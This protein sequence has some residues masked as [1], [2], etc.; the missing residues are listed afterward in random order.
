MEAIGQLTGGVAHDFNNIL[1][2]VRGNLELIRRKP[3]DPEKVLHFSEKAIEGTRRGSNLTAQLLTFSRE[4]SPE[5]R[6]LSVAKLFRGL[7][8]L[9]R[10]SLGPTHQLALEMPEDALCVV[11]DKTQLEMALLNTAVNARDAMPDGGVFQLSAQARGVGDDVELVPG[12]YVDVVARDTGLGMTPE[13]LAR[14]FDPFFTTKAVGKG[15]GLGLSQV[16]GMTRRAGGNTRLES[17]PGSGTSVILTLRRSDASE[18]EL[19]PETKPPSESGL[20]HST[21]VLVVDDDGDVRQVLVDALA[22]LGYSVLEASGG[23]AAIDVLTKNRVEAVIVDF[24]MPGMN[25]AELALKVRKMD[26]SLPIMMVS[27]YSDS[28]AITAAVGRGHPA[29]EKA[30]RHL[31]AAGVVRAGAAPADASERLRTV[32]SG[33]R[34]RYDRT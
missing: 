2:A 14:A 1:Q 34:A 28:A 22:G 26:D 4:Q 24:A 12:D 7:E 21:T 15:S 33:R 6:P 18:L 8:D 13:V 30:L 3:T 19:A 23:L 17:H 27:G 32:N 16:Y 29:A 25:G 11:A 31:I 5:L 9:L 10:T 20:R